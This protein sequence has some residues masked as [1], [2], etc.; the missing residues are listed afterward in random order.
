MAA[1]QA[2]ATSKPRHRSRHGSALMTINRVRA[3]TTN[4]LNLP[5]FE[6]QSPCASLF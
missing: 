5:L 1:E 4:H 3:G 6:D 2:S